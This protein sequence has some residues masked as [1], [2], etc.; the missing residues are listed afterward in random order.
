MEGNILNSFAQAGRVEP[1]RIGLP[2]YSTI[3]DDRIYIVHVYGDKVAVYDLDGKYKGH[4]AIK[5][6][7]EMKRLDLASLSPNV[8]LQVKELRERSYTSI[9]GL[10]SN[11]EY[12]IF[13]Y[14]RNGSEF[15]DAPTQHFLEF[16]D[17]KGNPVYRGINVSHR[18][19]QVD[20]NQ[21]YFMSYNAEA[22]YGELIVQVYR[23]TGF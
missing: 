14:S 21:F 18:L 16:Y 15:D 9:S 13:E 7:P 1:T 23:F 11:D 12:L 4:L 8:M 10:Y 3:Y 20:G 22:E 19:M 5:D 6:S 17:F 2:F